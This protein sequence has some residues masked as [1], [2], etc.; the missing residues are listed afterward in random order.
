M[1]RTIGFRIVIVMALCLCVAIMK[2]LWPDMIADCID[3][4]IGEK[5]WQ[6]FTRAPQRDDRSQYRQSPLSS[7]QR[8]GK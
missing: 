4:C 8:P 6:E 5:N 7:K 1:N 3:F 2:N